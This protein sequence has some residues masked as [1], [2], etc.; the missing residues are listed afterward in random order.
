[1]ISI[2]KYEFSPIWT[3]QFT[4]DGWF[5]SSKVSTLPKKK[6]VKIDHTSIGP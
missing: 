5:I 2:I 4:L 6:I 3:N 1:M